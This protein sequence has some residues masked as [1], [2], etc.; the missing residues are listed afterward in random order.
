MLGIPAALRADAE[1]EAEYAGDGSPV[2]LS[3]E[4]GE[5]RGGAAGF[6]YFPLPL[7]RW[8]EDLI[9]T[10]ANILLFRSEEIDGWCEGDSAPRGEALTLTW[11]LSKA[12]YG[13]R[14]SPGYR[15]RTAEEV[16]RV[17]GS[18]GLTGAFWRP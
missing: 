10:W 8:Y 4:G 12:W 16:E 14:L 6:V 5:L 18:L 1:I 15:D 9:F 2:R 7:G 3:V 17:F 11:E 13:D